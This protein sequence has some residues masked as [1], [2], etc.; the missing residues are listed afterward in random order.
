MLDL[1]DLGRS[2]RA[3]VQLGLTKLRKMVWG[4]ELRAIWCTAMRVINRSWAVAGVEVW[5]RDTAPGRASPG[6]NYCATVSLERAM[7]LKN[8]Y[9]YMHIA[10]GLRRIEKVLVFTWETRQLS[11]P[12]AQCVLTK[13]NQWTTLHPTGKEL[14][15]VCSRGGVPGCQAELPNC[16]ACG[17]LNE[18]NGVSESLETR[19]SITAQANTSGMVLASVQQLDDVV[20]ANSVLLWAHENASS[21]SGSTGAWDFTALMK[22]QDIIFFQDILFPQ[23]T[24]LSNKQTV[25]VP[26]LS[27][28]VYCGPHISA[29]VEQDQGEVRGMSSH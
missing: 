29:E 21:M 13:V 14:A 3:P 2:L 25:I 5:K 26:L 24:H 28:L 8:H 23:P 18:K 7:G 1:E 16:R 22:I 17:A 6:R 11:S 4:K 10:V 20:P 19:F 27:F 12:N 15:C 9:I